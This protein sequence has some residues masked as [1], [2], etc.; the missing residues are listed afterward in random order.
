V[1]MNSVLWAINLWQL[2]PD[3]QRGVRFL[4]HGF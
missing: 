1:A 4:G 3:C 2:S